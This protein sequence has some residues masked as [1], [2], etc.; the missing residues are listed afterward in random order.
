[1]LF[2][3]CG[4]CDDFDF[5]EC[6]VL[7]G[8]VHCNILLVMTAWLIETTQNVY[9]QEIY[10]HHPGGNVTSLISQKARYFV[11][12]LSWNVLLVATPLLILF[13]FFDMATLIF[14]CSS[15]DNGEESFFSLRQ[16]HRNFLNLILLLVH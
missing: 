9:F 6:E 14:L 2:S 3:P 4:K 1:M 10:L 16:I 7:P 8:F 11:E 5:S 12:I 13:F 15:S